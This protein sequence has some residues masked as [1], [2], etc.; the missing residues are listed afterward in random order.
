MS[1]QRTLMRGVL[2]HEEPHTLKK[3][4]PS[5]QVAAPLQAVQAA[6]AVSMAR[7]AGEQPH[8]AGGN[9]TFSAAALE[10]ARR[11]AFEEGRARGQAQGKEEA[12][13]EARGQALEQ[14]GAQARDEGYQDGLRRAQESAQARVQEA[15]AAMERQLR[16]AHS[17]RIRRLEQL[18]AALPAA[19]EGRLAQAEDDMLALAFEALCRLLGEQAA[20]A[21][22]LRAH[23]QQALQSWRSR[24][25]L[26]VHL[27][28]D[29][30][31]L[32]QRDA[33][34]LRSLPLTGGG[35]APAVHW[36]ADAEVA[37]G[38]CVLRSADGGLDARL[39]VQM[40]GLKDALLRIRSARPVASVSNT[41][42]SE[43]AA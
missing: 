18:A 34:L 33:A 30:V 13:S 5:A 2:V 7:P 9:E 40:Q 27:H 39:E 37:L 32:L 29:D 10:R 41:S 8:M 12:L 25:A 3:P 16:D 31:E 17:E 24:A 19:I 4:Q 20:S 1:S 26:S 11:E 36:V 21:E 15:V 35:D 6:S 42:A 43:P 23:L 22:G 28:P 14:A 38:G